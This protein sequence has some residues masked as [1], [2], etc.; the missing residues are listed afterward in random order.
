[1]SA[2]RTITVGKTISR[3][4][5]SAFFDMSIASAAQVPVKMAEMDTALA[6][7]RGDP[8]MNEVGVRAPLVA[9]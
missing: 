3:A 5:I 4:Q 8:N 2:S 7:A 9:D 1:M 6:M